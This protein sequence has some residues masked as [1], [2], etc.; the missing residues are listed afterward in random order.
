MFY[1]SDKDYNIQ[2][3][4]GTFV[5]DMEIQ[6]TIEFFNS[7]FKEQYYEKGIIVPTLHL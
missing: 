5:S 4:Q 3:I 6:K 7:D 2:H 1:R